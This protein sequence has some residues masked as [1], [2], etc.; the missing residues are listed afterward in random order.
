MQIMVI[1]VFRFCTRLMFSTGLLRSMYL[2][3][4]IYNNC[5]HGNGRV[6]VKL[7]EMC[8]CVCMMSVQCSYK[9]VTKILISSDTIYLVKVL[10]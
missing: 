4:S 7:N 6:L 9:T 8:N 5:L 2:Y 1:M 10:K 3:I